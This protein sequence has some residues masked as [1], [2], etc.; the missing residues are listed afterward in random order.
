MVECSTAVIIM[1]LKHFMTSGQQRS[2]YV[3]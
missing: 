1:G 3:S 2:W